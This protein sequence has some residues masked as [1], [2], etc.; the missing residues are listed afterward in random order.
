ML[1]ESKYVRASTSP[2]KASEG[3]AADLTKYTDRCHILFFIYDPD[4]AISDDEGY[5]ADI[6][7]KGRY[8]VCIVR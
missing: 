6:E 2:S 1:I 5:R 3:I 4:R 7:G 8:T